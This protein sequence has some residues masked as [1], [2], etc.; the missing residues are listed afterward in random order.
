MEV[1]D[2]C[3]RA[4]KGCWNYGFKEWRS[5]TQDE[6]WLVQWKAVVDFMAAN[7]RNPS[8]YN[9]NSGDYIAIGLSII[10]S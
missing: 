7:H 5:M 4:F 6:R 9:D 10:R 2:G 3:V 1:A 8:R